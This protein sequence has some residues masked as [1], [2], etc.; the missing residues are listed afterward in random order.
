MQTPALTLLALLTLIAAIFVHGRLASVAGRGPGLWLTRAVLVL[1]GVGFGWAMLRYAAV[2][3]EP[4]GVVDRVLIFATA[5]GMVHVPGMF[6]LL[7]KRWRRR[8]D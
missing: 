5:F 3:P 8:Q 1:A 6:I 7:L 4:P 2:A